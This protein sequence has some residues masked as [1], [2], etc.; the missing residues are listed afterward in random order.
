MYICI[1]RGEEG[2]QKKIVGSKEEWWRRQARNMIVHLYIELAVDMTVS[3]LQA[4]N[5]GMGK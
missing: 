5:Q 4:E 2:D 3:E 1:H